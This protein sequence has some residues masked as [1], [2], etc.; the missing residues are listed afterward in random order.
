[1]KKLFII[2]SLLSLNFFSDAQSDFEQNTTLENLVNG[3]FM[4]SKK[5]TDVEGSPYFPT[6]WVSGTVTLKAG[7]IY[8]LPFL[9]LNTMNGSLEFQANDKPYDVVNSIREFTLGS[10][11]FKNGFESIGG[12]DSETFYEVIYDG[13]NKLLCKHESTIRTEQPY[14]SASKV[15]TFVSKQTYFLSKNDGKMYEVKKNLKNLLMAFN[16]QTS[17]IEQYCKREDLKLR[18]WNDAVKVLEFADSL[19]KQ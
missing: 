18:S 8:S 5:Y 17:Q 2:L 14:N 12:N 3:K 15:S 9:R 7:K 19:E 13:K 10:M 1:M 4:G 16:S 11:I 6:Q